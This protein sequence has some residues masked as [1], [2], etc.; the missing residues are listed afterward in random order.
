MLN[1][2]NASLRLVSKHS[3]GF[4]LGLVQLGK[5]TA[6]AAKAPGLDTERHAVAATGAHRVT[7]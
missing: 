4:A 7:P 3:L 2:E 6:S 1:G 5:A